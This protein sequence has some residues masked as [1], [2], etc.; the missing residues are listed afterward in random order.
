ML[1]GLFAFRSGSTP[2]TGLLVSPE[3]AWLWLAEEPCPGPGGPVSLLKGAM[4]RTAT[5]TYYLGGSCL[6]KV[7]WGG[8]LGE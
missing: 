7:D 6:I 8:R 3:P 5:T 2:G 1:R 4:S